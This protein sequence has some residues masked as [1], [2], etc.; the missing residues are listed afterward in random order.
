M[1]GIVRGLKI[2]LMPD[3]RFIKVL[4]QLIQRFFL[5]E[6]PVVIEA[7]AMDELDRAVNAEAVAGEPDLAISAGGNGAKQFVLRDDGQTRE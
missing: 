7:G 4:L 2:D 6:G 5:F 1:E 3:L